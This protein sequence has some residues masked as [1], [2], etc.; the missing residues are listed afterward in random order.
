MAARPIIIDCDPGHDDALA[1]LLALGSPEDLEVV[2]ITA[3]AGNAPL[4]LTEEN[5]RKVCELAG[6]PDVPVHAGCAGPMVRP[7]A[8]ADY[9][10]GAS[11]L[12]GYDLPEPEMPLAPGHAVD[13]IIDI[14]RARPERTVT[15]CPTGPLTNVAMAMIKAPETVPRIREIV[16]MGGAIGLGNVTPAAEFN[17]FVDP[18]AADVVFRS[19][20]PIVMF[21][22]DVTRQA[23]V[24]PE[25][26]ETI[27]RLDTPVGR[28]MASLLEFYNLY[29]QTKRGQPG[30]PLHDPC[31]IAWL[32]QPELFEGRACHVAIETGS[33]L[34]MGRTVVDWTGRGRLDQ[35]GEP[36]NAMVMNQVDPDGFFALLT[37]RLGRLTAA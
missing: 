16:L 9:I 22:L 33:E 20:V 23:V 11:G 37:E 24:T 10:H 34:C 6:R 27:R 13:A 36:A 3:V 4:M 12:D 5:A 31:V 26:L 29:A 21:G 7:L 15:L 30:A 19:G 14:L 8:I 1:I 35:D 25:R 32:L 2:A 28:A 17:I 18:H